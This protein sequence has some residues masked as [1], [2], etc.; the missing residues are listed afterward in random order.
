MFVCGCPGP[1]YP[2]LNWPSIAETFTTYLRAGRRRGQRRTQPAD[3]DERRGRLHSCTSSSSIGSTSCTRWVQLF[4]AARSGTSPPASMAVPARSAPARRD[5]AVRASSVTACGGRARR[6]SAEAAGQRVRV[7]VADVAE[8]DHARAASPAAAAPT[9]RRPAAAYAAGRPAHRL[10]R[11]VDQDVQRPCGGDRVGQRDHLG[12]IAQVDADHAQP[13]QPVGAV[14]HGG[15]PAHGVVREAGG[16]RGV[17]AVAQQPQRD[18]HADLGPSAGEQRAAPGQVGARVA[19]G[20]VERGARR[21]ELVVERVDHGVAVL[22]DVAGPRPQQRARRS[23]RS[24][25]TPAA[26]PASRRRCA[27]ARRWRWKRPPRG[28]RPPPRPA[29]RG[30]GPLHRLEDARGGPA[31]GHGVGV[32]GRQRLT[33]AS[34][35]RQVLS[36]SGSIAVTLERVRAALHTCPK[37]RASDPGNNCKGKRPARPEAKHTTLEYPALQAVQEPVKLRTKCHCPPSPTGGP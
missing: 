30:G 33:S 26:G 11:V 23:P 12:R 4:T 34:T 10:R 19:L 13:V 25:W 27:P 5:R 31:H 24:R 28:R 20:P 16:D 29:W 21:A 7:R 32:L 22:A 1:L 14:R 36:F 8:R 35:S 37:R 3:Q 18:V 15:E 6:C 17:G 2:R 9:R